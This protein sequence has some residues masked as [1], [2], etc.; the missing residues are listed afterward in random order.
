MA[1][2]S[3]QWAKILQDLS[4]KRSSIQAAATFALEKPER[5]TEF[6]ASVVAR[7]QVCMHECM[8]RSWTLRRTTH[9]G[10]LCVCVLPAVRRA[11]Q[12]HGAPLP[13]A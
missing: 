3:S 13:G 4:E 7:L 6:L 11:L 2:A 10:A 9:I 8:Q 5:A 12:A 1:E